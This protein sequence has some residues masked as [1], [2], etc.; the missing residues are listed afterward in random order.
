[1]ASSNAWQREMLGSVKGRE[2]ELLF[3]A[4]KELL[5]ANSAI[6]WGCYDHNCHMNHN[7][8]KSFNR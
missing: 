7:R 1:M 6:T 5:G 2:R 8:H 4:V 3:G